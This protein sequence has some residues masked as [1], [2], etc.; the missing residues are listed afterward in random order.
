VD[1]LEKGRIALEPPLG[2]ERARALFGTPVSA[3]GLAAFDHRTSY[4]EIAGRDRWEVRVVSRWVTATL[5]QLLKDAPAGAVLDVGCGGQP[6]RALVESNQRPYVG[7]DVVQN[8]N[9]TVAV[10]GDLE[11]VEPAT[12]TYPL[13]LCTEVL[14]HVADIDLAFRGLRRLL[15]PG[16][17]AI[18]TVPFLFPVHMEPYDYR[19]L[20]E[21]GIAR[22]AADHGCDVV[23]CV[24]LGTAAD[25]VATLIADVSVLPR[26]RTVR[27]RVKTVVLRAAKS[28]IVKRLDHPSLSD[29]VAIN[30][31]FYL[32]NGVVLKAR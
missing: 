21:Y 31:N 3:S 29:H 16:G 6:F 4:D 20:T 2:P 26:D 14:E 27:S 9:N 22:L 32:C 13:V 25:A 19:R 30:S 17:I 28:W 18:L 7:M 15:V 10:F 24:R 1:R 23:S 12:A 5:P 11:H 8:T